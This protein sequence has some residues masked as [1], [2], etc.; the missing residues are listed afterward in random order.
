[1]QAASNAV[2]DHYR[3]E[4][5]RLRHLLESQLLDDTAELDERGPA[6]QLQAIETVHIIEQALA[7]LPP[8]TQ[9]I[10]YLYRLEG[11]SQQTIASTLD[12]SRSTVERR[13]GKAIAHWQAALQHADPAL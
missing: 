3:A 13:L 7:Q 6:R 4:H 2:I 8:L 9:R 1:F 12:I 5:C 10:F 11:L